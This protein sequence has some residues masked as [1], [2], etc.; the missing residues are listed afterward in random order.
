M[1]TAKVLYLYIINIVKLCNGNLV[2]RPGRKMMF[3]AKNEHLGSGQ[4]Y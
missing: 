2:I 3:S 1:C 4:C